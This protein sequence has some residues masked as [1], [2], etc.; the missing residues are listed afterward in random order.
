M[1]GGAISLIGQGTVNVCGL[2]HQSV[3]RCP[4]ATGGI[5]AA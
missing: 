5:S 1:H 2:T 4:V 3:K